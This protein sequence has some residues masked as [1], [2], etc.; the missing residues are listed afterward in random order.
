MLKKLSSLLFLSAIA[1]MAVSQSAYAMRQAAMESAMQALEDAESVL[2]DATANKGGH[3]VKALQLIKKAKSE[4]RQ[5]IR[6]ANARAN[7]MQLKQKR[8][9]EASEALRLKN[10]A[11]ERTRRDREARERRNDRPAERGDRRRGEAQSA[12]DRKYNTCIRQARNSERQIQAC[13]KKFGKK[14]LERR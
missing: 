14:R 1:V 7:E 10:E 9:R 3:R 4:I 2:K 5:G 13:N 8:E 6:F 11:R 12:Q